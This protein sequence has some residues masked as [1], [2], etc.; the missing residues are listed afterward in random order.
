MEDDSR[1]PQQTLN[2]SQLRQKPSAKTKGKT[3]MKNRRAVISDGEDDED[4]DSMPWRS[5]TVDE[6]PPS[7]PP[8]VRVTAPSNTRGRKGKSRADLQDLDSYREDRPAATGTKRP[9]PLD[10]E[11]VMDS[12]PP[13]PPTGSDM[14]AAEVK[15]PL[16]KKKLPP[17]K[18]IKLS[19]SSASSPVSTS[20]ATPIQV[21]IE[22]PKFNVDNT[23]LPAPPSSLPRKPA[24][25]AGNADLDLLNAD[26]YK[27]LF[28]VSSRII[29]LY[30]RSWC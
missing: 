9:R 17:I 21:K 7:S 23:G 5:D 10:S 26:V 22:K 30:T 24:A 1:N 4:D 8:Q 18:K 11:P 19:D 20:K 28:S 13:S 16:Q 3:S 15:E 12:K 6:D 2:R 14:T 29:V 27:Q 25:T